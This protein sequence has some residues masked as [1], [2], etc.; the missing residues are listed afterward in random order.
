MNDD[1][2]DYLPLSLT[3]GIGPRMRT[4]LLERFGTPTAVLAAPR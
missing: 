3:P 4:Q 2:L 1:L